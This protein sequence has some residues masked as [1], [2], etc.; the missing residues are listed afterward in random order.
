MSNLLVPLPSSLVEEEYLL[1]DYV[2]GRLK[3]HVTSVYRLV[4]SGRLTAI[5]VGN[6]EQDPRGIRILRSSFERFLRESL[7]AADA[8]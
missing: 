3:L 1:A 5:R 4:K 6:G 2:A 8:A 7:V